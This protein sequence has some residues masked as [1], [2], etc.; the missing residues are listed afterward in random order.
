MWYDETAVSKKI[1]ER[2]KVICVLSILLFVY[3][4]GVTLPYTG[5]IR[6]IH[7]HLHLPAVEAK[8]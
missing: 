2:K 1:D 4:D 6:N 7:T 8:F 3:F 5:H